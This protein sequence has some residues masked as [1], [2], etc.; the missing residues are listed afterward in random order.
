MFNPSVVIPP[1]CSAT[2]VNVLSNKGGNNFAYATPQSI[3]IRTEKKAESGNVTSSYPVTGIYGSQAG[4]V[5]AFDFNDSLVAAIV[6]NRAQQQKIGHSASRTV[7]MWNVVDG[8]IQEAKIPASLQAKLQV[9]GQPLSIC[10]AGKYHIIIG[11]A[12]GRL[13]SL[14]TATD[15]AEPRA[16]LLPQP[17]SATTPSRVVVVT[18]SKVRPELVACGTAD[19]TLGLFLLS[20]ST[21]LR[22]T[23]SVQPFPSALPVSA[24]AFSPFND[25]YLALGSSEGALSLFSVDSNALIQSFS[26]NAKDV[27]A[28]A[29][30]TWEQGSV[31][32]TSKAHGYVMKFNSN[33]KNEVERICPGTS[34]PKPP[35]EDSEM[36]TPS[37]KLQLSKAAGEEGSTLSGIRGIACMEGQVLAL[38]LCDGS[39]HVYQL[40]RQQTALHTASQ[41]TRPALCAAMAKHDPQMFATAG[42]DGKVLV[43]STSL[44]NQPMHTL[45]V[46]GVDAGYGVT[47][48][49]WSSN[50]KH[51]YAGLHNGE[52]ISFAMNTQTVNWKIPVMAGTPVSAM[53]YVTEGGM[54]LV[55][56]KD[57]VVVVSKDGKIVRRIK[58]PCP[59]RAI[60]LEPTRGK[61]LL[62]GGSDAKVYVY[63]LQTDP[64]STQPDVPLMTLVG[65]TEAITSLSFNK[66]NQTFFV[67]SSEDGTTRVWDLSANDAQS[68]STQSK[69][70]AAGT[71]G[72]RSVAWCGSLAP[73]LLLT[74]GDD[75][76]VHLW[77]TRVSHLISKS[78]TG[79]APVLALMAHPERPAMAT[80]L[81]RDGTITIWSLDTLRQAAL[82]AAIGMLEQRLA[83]VPD[84]SAIMRD[85]PSLSAS[86]GLAT[87]P[88]VQTLVSELRSCNKPIERLEKITQYF[89]YGVVGIGDLRRQAAITVNPAANSLNLADS[90]RQSIMF[91]T[92]QLVEAHRAQ[93]HHL[94]EKA[95]GKTVTNAGAA[96]KKSR[97]VEAADRLFKAGLLEEAI[98]VWGEAGEWDTA[99]A[100]APVLGKDFW[101]ALCVKA[102]TAMEV[103]GRVDRAATYLIAAGDSARAAQL[104]A[105]APSPQVDAALAIARACPQRVGAAP[106]AAANAGDTTVDSNGTSNVAQALAEERLNALHQLNA[107]AIEAAL[108][109][110]DS[111]NDEA[112]RVLTEAGE[113]LLA[114]LLVHTVPLQEQNSIDMAYR[115]DLRQCC[116]HRQWDAA[117]FCAAT[118][119]QHY[120]GYATVIAA[121]QDSIPADEVSSC[122]EKLRGFYERVK[123]ECSRQQISLDHN[124]IQ[125][126]HAADG[127]ASQNQLAAMIIN[128]DPATGPFTSV[129]LIQ[130]FTGFLESLLGVALQDIDGPNSAFY[131]R[132]AYSICGYV[133]FPKVTPTSPLP[134]EH[135]TFLAMSLLLS[136]LM[137]VKLY[138]LPRVLNYAF[139]K[140]SE[141]GQGFPNVEAL[142]GRVHGC[143]GS[144][145]PTSTD[146]HCSPSGADILLFDPAKKG[147]RIVSLL[148]NEVI[149]GPAVPLRNIGAPSDAP[150][151]YLA[152]EEALQ[153]GL[154]SHF[155]PLMDGSRFFVV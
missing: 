136:T 129:P 52:V 110:H 141:L 70:L 125:Q 87:S 142:I 44:P 71:G 152:R 40:P 42:E 9:E 132:Q 95:R 128:S 78:R 112:V 50:G 133:S 10:V 13:I 26:Y 37:V 131:L 122:T 38:G 140:A 130:S 63:Q 61:A 68:I 72:V 107:P 108:R 153:W 83:A 56:G 36:T 124:V 67:S 17:T 109:L 143:L 19:G 149:S 80:S 117:L 35:Q 103:E 55:A 138:R 41:H 45:N 147:G 81:A 8:E 21:G 73:Y 48:I 58:V 85:A 4:D 102:A 20:A 137:C 18:A 90:L 69:V 145:S 151:G 105:R 7:M 111:K 47:C 11:T 94:L 24:L 79:H 46:S 62:V 134:N 76:A 3:I 77:D 22:L 154:I 114:H 25:N 92:A 12:S 146:V 93:A 135:R 148:T 98:N 27:S 82:D 106:N 6:I 5:I 43:W 100:V 34:L 39:V 33:S 155:S 53:S 84:P 116:L 51:L 75:A 91:P 59:V 97:L 88:P 29:W 119:T 28:L 15:G 65:H 31:Y 120:D 113:V 64:A 23:A 2:A 16:V 96:Y 49:Q 150:A 127:M 123:Q 115:L 89:D 139:S 1:G 32:V 104:Y 14:N 30:S 121:F 99:L 86:S 144:Y 126:Q 101:A 66:V 60:D 54:V 118:M 74:A 57:G